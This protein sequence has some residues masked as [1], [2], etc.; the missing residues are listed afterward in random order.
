MHVKF[1][2]LSFLENPEGAAA[3]GLCLHS[4]G[5]ELA[6]GE[7]TYAS[8]QARALLSQAP[9][10]RPPLRHAMRSPAWPPSPWLHLPL[11]PP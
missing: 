10:L 4:T 9:G 1:R 6:L 3:L 7:A 2:I 5:E 8:L 11:L